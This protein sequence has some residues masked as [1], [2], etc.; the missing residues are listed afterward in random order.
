MVIT[1]A[2]YI[3]YA[4][5][6]FFNN[7]VLDMMFV[8]RRIGSKAVAAIIHDPNARHQ[9]WE[10]STSVSSIAHQFLKYNCA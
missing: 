1:S 7:H 6:S 4:S 8:P 10:P 3:L 5:H 2:S 9:Y